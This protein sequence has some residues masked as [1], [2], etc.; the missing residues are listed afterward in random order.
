MLRLEQ[1]F[2]GQD[3]HDLLDQQDDSFHVVSGDDYVL[4][5]GGGSALN[6]AIASS[7]VPISATCPA[8][9]RTGFGRRSTLA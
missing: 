5:A 1:R 9:A 4:H 6:R 2:A 8:S 3:R 7:D